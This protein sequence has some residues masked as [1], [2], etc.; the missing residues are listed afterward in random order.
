MK[1]SLSFYLFTSF[2]LII[3]F[4]GIQYQV[5]TTVKYR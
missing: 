3:I 1:P 5:N 4:L 2:G